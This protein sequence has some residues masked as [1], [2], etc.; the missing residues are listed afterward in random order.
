MHGL[1]KLANETL[2]QIINNVTPNDITN[3]SLCSKEIHR[4]CQDALKLHHERK[5]TLSDMVF[6]GC[7]V[8]N[9]V[10]HPM[11]LVAEICNNW[12]VA[13]YVKSMTVDCSELDHDLWHAETDEEMKAMKEQERALA[14]DIFFIEF[15]NDVQSLMAKSRYFRASDKVGSAFP[16]SWQG[17]RGSLLA[18]LLVLL[19]NLK[20]ISLC[21]YPWEA[22]PYKVLNRIAYWHAVAENEGTCI[23]GESCPDTGNT[24]SFRD[25]LEEC[26]SFH[27]R[28]AP[29]NMCHD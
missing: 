1:L 10:A 20:S 18:L 4:L 9:E 17:D 19:P 12:R 2:Y 24:E 26:T 3:F 7:W 15:G 14:A 8:H 16:Y 5:R 29:A 21:E 6:R 11:T 28:S 27:P 22:E 23:L 13:Y 25:G